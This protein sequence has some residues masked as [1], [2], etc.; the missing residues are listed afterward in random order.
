M[1]HNAKLVAA[2]KARTEYLGGISAMT[3]YRW[4]KAG[5]LPKPIQIRK[6]NYYREADLI[7]V[8]Q[9]FAAGSEGAAA[10]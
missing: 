4:R 8:Q 5:V 2:P 7:A 1:T 10:G 6:R 3:E 9:R